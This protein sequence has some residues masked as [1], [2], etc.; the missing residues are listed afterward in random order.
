MGELEIPCADIYA[1]PGDMA[2]S[3][4]RDH[5]RYPPL[6]SK[7][8]PPLPPQPRT[9]FCITP[10]I[11]A[12]LYT[13]E[14]SRFREATLECCVATRKLG[15]AATWGAI[16]FGVSRTDSASS[17][18]VPRQPEDFWFKIDT[19]LKVQFPVYHSWSRI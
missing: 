2:R 17:R 5:L 3:Q 18:S 14:G 9:S 16:V 11:A 4:S 12:K 8:P 1:H 13:R 7:D 15:R 10:P 6:P 19:F